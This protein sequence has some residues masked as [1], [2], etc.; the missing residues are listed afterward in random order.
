VELH[1]VLTRLQ[2]MRNSPK[3]Y[4]LFFF[5]LCT[6][7]CNDGSS[8]D[9]VLPSGSNAIFVVCEGNYGSNNSE[10]SILDT[11]ETDTSYSDVFEPM[12]GAKLGDYAHNMVVVDSTGYIAVMKSNKIEVINTRTFR[13]LSHIDV[14]SPRDLAYKDGRLYV[15]CYDDSSIMVIQFIPSMVFQLKLAHRPDEIKILNNKAYVSNAINSSDSIISVFNI[16]TL[17]APDT[18][19]VGQKPV[20]IAADPIRNKIYVACQ[21]AAASE[22]FVSV[23]DPA[24]DAIESKIETGINPVKVAVGDT[25]IAYITSNLGPIRVRNLNS[26]AEVTVPGNFYSIAFDGN[27]LFATDAQDF[28]TSGLLRRFDASFNNTKSYPVGVAPSAI[29]FQK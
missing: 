26:S 9:K 18:I 24:T 22:G 19:V 2:L 1:R 5:I 17:Q 6:A 14:L 15:T 8:R 23:I 16:N 28:L 29:V 21:G 11:A 27:S 3:R 4:V 12:N 13:S 25:S 7:A 10:L 20:S